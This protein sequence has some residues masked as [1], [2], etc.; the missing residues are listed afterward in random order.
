[1]MGLPFQEFGSPQ[2]RITRDGDLVLVPQQW[3][4]CVVFLGVRSGEEKPDATG[5]FASA[6]P[7]GGE[8]GSH[9]YLVTAAHSVR[10]HA[11]L[12][13]LINT[14]D[15]IQSLPL[16]DWNEENA[17][18]RHPTDEENV[19]IAVHPL[20]LKFATVLKWLEYFWVPERLFFD[21]H[22]L[23][24][25]DPDRGFG[26]ADELATIGLF[27]FHPGTEQTAPIA[28]SGNLAMVPTERIEVKDQATSKVT[29]EWLYL[30][31]LRSIG[32]MSGSPVFMKS[33]APVGV[34]SQVR[35]LGVNVGH[36]EARGA[37]QE[38]PLNEGIAM[39]T[40]ARMLKDVL[41]QEALVARRK[42]DHEEAQ[43][44]SGDTGGAVRDRA[45][46]EA[47]DM[48]ERVSL[49]PLDFEDAVKGI[50]EAK[51]PPD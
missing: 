11:G 3:M 18:Y 32:G 31:E 8:A 14:A 45:K 10:D 17:W 50:L 21:E 44:A 41:F 48:D 22:K 30:T 51:P 43:A 7:P 1:M 13:M 42:K 4:K 36:W 49:D 26:V 39:V 12:F 24:F 38:P 37:K 16:P 5:F 28:R 2:F 46:P 35:L 23:S 40:P 29:H 33:R 15:G 20:S 25:D 34:D 9:V 27:H 6:P 47:R 19:D